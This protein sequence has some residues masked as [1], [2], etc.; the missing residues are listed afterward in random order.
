MIFHDLF[1][2]LDF[3]SGCVG[4]IGGLVELAGREDFYSGGGGEQVVR[5][6][7]VGFAAVLDPLGAGV[8]YYVDEAFLRGEV[9][10]LLGYLV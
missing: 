2:G 4:G 7:Q 8:G 1:E 10:V 6:W 9:Q 3:P 5:F